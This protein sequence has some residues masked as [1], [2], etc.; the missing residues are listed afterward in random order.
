MNLKKRTPFF[1]LS[2]SSACSGS[3]ALKLQMRGCLSVC[4]VVLACLF[5]R[6]E[7]CVGATIRR[8]TTT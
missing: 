5:F 6:D 8:H 2:L 1:V 4:H 3:S 7:R